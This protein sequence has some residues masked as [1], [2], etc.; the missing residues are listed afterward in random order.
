MRLS[1]FFFVLA[2]LFVFEADSEN[3]MMARRS[4]ATH[5]APKVLLMV[6]DDDGFVDVFS[7]LEPLYSTSWYRCVDGIWKGTNTHEGRRALRC[8]LPHDMI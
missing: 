3:N 1:L 5:S 8:K 7:S 6:M 4:L 2:L